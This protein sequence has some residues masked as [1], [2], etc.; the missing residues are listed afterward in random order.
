MPAIVGRFKYLRKNNFTWALPLGYD[1][2]NARQHTTGRMTNGPRLMWQ[3]VSGTREPQAVVTHFEVA[4][5]IT[6]PDGLE[7]GYNYMSFRSERAR[8]GIH[9]LYATSTGR[10]D[11]TVCSV[12]GEARSPTHAKGTMEKLDLGLSVLGLRG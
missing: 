9:L 4:L 1:I 6:I 2:T 12:M 10:L 3:R 8:D 11:S 7:F 5:R